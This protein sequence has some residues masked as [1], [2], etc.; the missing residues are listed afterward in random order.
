MAEKDRPSEPRLSTEP[1]SFLN[2]LTA[3][4]TKSFSHVSSISILLSGNRVS[5]NLVTLARCQ[6]QVCFQAVLLGV[7]IEVAS[8]KRV[9]LV[10]RAAL[11]DTALFDHKNLI[12]PSDR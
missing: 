3:D 12:G 2:F 6:E 10:V 7:E 5:G 8:L 4:Q 1:R 9:Q 11:H